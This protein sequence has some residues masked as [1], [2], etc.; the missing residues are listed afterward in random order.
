MCNTGTQIINH[1]LY[2]II[3]KGAPW[4]VQLLYTETQNNCISK[5]EAEE[6]LKLW[7]QSK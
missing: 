3:I 4:Q 7:L 2:V 5:S 1:A 6:K